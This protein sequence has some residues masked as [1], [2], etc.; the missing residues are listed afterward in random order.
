MRLELLWSPRLLCERLAVESQRRRRLASLKGTAAR[1]LELG[2]I[3]SLEL[4]DIVRPDEPRVI[5]DVGACIGTWS[6]LASSRLPGAHVHAFEPLSEHV[7]KFVQLTKPYSNI[8]LHQV[9]LGSHGGV[10]D[11][12]VASSSDSSSLLAL[13]EVMTAEFGIAERRRQ[14][15]RVAPLDDYVST[16]GIPLP[17]FIKLDVQ[18]FELDV[19]KGAEY[20]LSQARWVLCEVSFLQYYR[21]QPLFEDVA[22]FLHARGF[23]VCALGAQT[24]LGERLTQTDVL[25]RKNPIRL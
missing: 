4:L 24:P 7:S 23:S 14:T 19:M 15:V 17:D 12:H 5:Y 21:D 1:H 25:F 2:H 3:D 16:T 20:C 10:Q 13:T 11:L 22:A 18:G 9:A 8:S 6:L